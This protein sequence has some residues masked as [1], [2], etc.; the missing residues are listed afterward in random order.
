MDNYKLES[1]ICK[2]RKRVIFSILCI[3][4]LIIIENV[5]FKLESVISLLLF[6]IFIILE[7]ISTLNTQ[8]ALIKIKRLNLV[9]GKINFWNKKNCIF[10]DKNLIFYRK[11]KVLVYEYDDIVIIQRRIEYHRRGMPDFLIIEFKDEIKFETKILDDYFVNKDI[12]DVTT[13]LFEKNNNIIEKEFL[14]VF[15]YLKF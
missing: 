15:G 6:W 13:Y 9:S 5:Y 12:K 14:A 3:I 4:I 10:T 11:G 7:L 1:L 8:I 2:N